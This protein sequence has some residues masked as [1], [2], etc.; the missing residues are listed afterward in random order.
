[1]PEVAD[2]RDRF[3]PQEAPLRQIDQALQ[4]GLGREGTGLEVD[5]EAWIA[6][7]DPPELVG[8]FVDGDRSACRPVSP[9]HPSGC[10][11]ISSRAGMKAADRRA[12]DVLQRHRRRQDVR[13]EQVGDGL[14]LVDRLQ[15]EERIVSACTR[16]HMSARIRPVGVRSNE[17]RDDPDGRDATSAVTR[18]PSQRR[19]SAPR[20]CSIRSDERSTNPRPSSSASTCSQGSVVAV[21]MVL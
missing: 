14:R 10:V 2:L 8:S 12:T 21:V 20:T 11:T 18:S 15:D 1:M 6:A 13:P 16:S 7:G 9:D 17:R 19:A 4:A 3:L 5:A